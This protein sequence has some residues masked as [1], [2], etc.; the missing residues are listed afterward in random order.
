MIQEL[1]E[2]LELI[3]T[4]SK[5]EM[6]EYMDMEKLTEQRLQLRAEMEAYKAE[7]EAE[8]AQVAQAMS[9]L[10]YAEAVADS[11]QG[12]PGTEGETQ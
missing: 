8:L 10:D 5:E 11:F 7:K 4:F 6:R 2:R 12:G 9:D 3:L 1:L